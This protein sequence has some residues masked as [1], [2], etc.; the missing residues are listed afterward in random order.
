MKRRICYNFLL[1]FS[2]PG[3][4][5]VIVDTGS[6][7][8]TWQWLQNQSVV[9]HQIVW[10]DDFSKA[11]NFSLWHATGN[12]ILWLDADDRFDKDA[13]NSLL[14]HLESFSKQ[15]AF[16]FTISNPLPGGQRESFKQIRLFPNGKEIQFRGRVHEQLGESIQESGLTLKQLPFVI[17]HMGYESVSQR[18]KKIVRNHKLL[19]KSFQEQPEEPFVCMELGN[20]Y[21]QQKEWQKALEF[22]DLALEL[23]NNKRGSALDGLEL[24]IGNVYREINDDAQWEWYKRSTQN[25]PQIQAPHYFLAKQAVE[26]NQPEIAEMHLRILVGQGILVSNLA[27]SN[28]SIFTNACSLYAL[29]LEQKGLYKKA[30]ETLDYSW[31]QSGQ[32]AID[33][34][35]VYE[36]C[37][38]AEGLAEKQKW[39]GRLNPNQEKVF[40]NQK[41]SPELQKLT[42]QDWHLLLASLFENTEDAEAWE[43]L[44]Y[45]VQKFD[46]LE[47]TVIS[48]QL[49]LGWNREEIQ[50]KLQDV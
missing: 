12:W 20:S 34:E 11:R 18:E 42:R 7:D 9:S 35:F 24:L 13:L 23:R 46:N 19:I 48:L 43:K 47:R 44:K 14:N 40:E 30:L 8:G 5:W 41:Q 37:V 38:K 22:Y 4:E 21:F 28:E 29:L 31:E 50:G 3:L 25:V 6:Q 26:L 45:L 33:P 2:L 16:S 1:F 17:H 32:L 15:T 39:L 36:L 27:E 10:E 49:K